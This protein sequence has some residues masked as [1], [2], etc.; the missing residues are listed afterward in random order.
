MVVRELGVDE[1]AL[2]A[3]LRRRIRV[4][5]TDP[6]TVTIDPE[7][8]REVSRDVCRRRRLM[9][10]AVASYATGPKQLRVA[11]A[12]PTDA[13]AIAEVEHHSGCRVEPT[14]MTLS[15]VEEL[16]ETSYRQYVTEVMRRPAPRPRKAEPAGEPAAGGTVPFRRVVD[17]ADLGLRVEAL[18][19]LLV[20]KGVLG[21]DEYEEAVR[22]L[23]KQRAT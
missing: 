19:H 10:L 3:A 1:V 21:E 6:A 16:V 12:D 11:M 8:L 2:V 15:A 9:P 20:E 14:L 13:V 18:V 22:E 23:M 7:A 4:S 17:D 5:V